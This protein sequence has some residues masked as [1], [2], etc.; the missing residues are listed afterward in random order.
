MDELCFIPAKKAGGGRSA[1]LDSSPDQRHNVCVLPAD[2]IPPTGLLGT[3]K[4]RRFQTDDISGVGK[5]GT[6]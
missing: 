3:L 6:S 4:E 5:G 1:I 2:H